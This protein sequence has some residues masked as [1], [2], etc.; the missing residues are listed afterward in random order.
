LNGIQHRSGIYCRRTRK[1]PDGPGLA[2]VVAIKTRTV[3]GRNNHYLAEP[4]G[5]SHLVLH[6][7]VI[8]SRSVAVRPSKTRAVDAADTAV[9]DRFAVVVVAVVVD[10]CQGALCR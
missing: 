1:R 5:L 4:S 6:F 8:A 3:E 7:G 9:V 10:C 2:A